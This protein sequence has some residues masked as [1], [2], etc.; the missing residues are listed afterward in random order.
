MHTHER[1]LTRALCAATLCF[2][3]AGADARSEKRAGGEMSPYLAPECT[4]AQEGTRRVAILYHEMCPSAEKGTS[5]RS[6]ELDSSCRDVYKLYKMRV[7]FEESACR[8]PR[9]A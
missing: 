7:E 4:T 9:S 3:A 5:H 2:A 8:I 6:Q 1:K